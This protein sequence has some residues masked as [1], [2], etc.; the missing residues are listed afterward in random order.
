MK[1]LNRL[2]LDCRTSYRKIGIE[3]GLTTKSVKARVDKMMSGGI[4]Q[5]FFVKV[6]PEVAGYSKLLAIAVR[7][8]GNKAPD[9]IAS[10]LNLLGDSCFKVKCIGGIVVFGLLVRKE[11]EE[12]VG[13]LLDAV[14]PAL[15]ES[16]SVASPY[17]HVDLTRIDYKIIKCLISNPRME[18][19]DI[20][21]TTAISEK[22]VS[23]RLERMRQNRVLEFSVICDPSAMGG[24]I[25]VHIGVNVEKSYYRQVL[26]R[27]HAE[28]QEY[29]ILS[30]AMLNQDDT[31]SLLLMSENVFTIDAIM[32]RVESYQGVKRADVSFPTYL[33][34]DQRAILKGIDAKLAGEGALAAAPPARPHKPHV[35]R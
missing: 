4:I 12:K 32:T 34:H 29:F 8:S 1:I 7:Q 28:L 21:R 2:A 6:S 25:M 27:I 5:S 23:R 31:I 35:K 9:D 14:K 20:A 18:I 11:A 19:S 16:T 15:V 30:S 3:V 13:L 26:E 10:R 22:T 17:S 24:Y 33:E